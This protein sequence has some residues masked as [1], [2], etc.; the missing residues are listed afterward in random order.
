VKNGCFG[1]CV[2]QG[3]AACPFIVWQRITLYPFIVLTGVNANMHA[4]I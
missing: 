1:V 4:H 2:Y 3:C